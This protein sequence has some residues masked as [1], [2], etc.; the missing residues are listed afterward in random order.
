MCKATRCKVRVASPDGVYDFLNLVA[1][2]LVSGQGVG[3]ADEVQVTY[4]RDGCPFIYVE[5]LI[6]D[7]RYFFEVSA[8]SGRNA[9]SGTD[10]EEASTGRGI[11]QD[12]N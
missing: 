3:S 11:I 8:Q 5:G 12:F 10:S 7:T 4:P 2:P 6:P 9:N 1:T